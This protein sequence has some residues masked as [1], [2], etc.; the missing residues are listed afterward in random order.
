MQLILQTQKMGNAAV[1]RCKGRLV[2]GDEIRALQMEVE[3]LTPSTK[4]IALQLAE[5]NFIDSGAL[6]ALVRL[7]GVLRNTG[8][9]L[10]LCEVSPF[11]LQVLQATNLDRVFHLYVSER[12]AIGASSVRGP[13]PEDASRPF[14]ARVVCID[15][16]SDLLAYLRV[17]LQRSGYDVFT[18]R[19]PSDAVIF[20]KTTQSSIV[21]CGPGMSSNEPALRNFRQSA[22]NV[23]L[24]MLPLDFSTAEASH[25][26][27]DLVKR[28][29]T[30]LN[31]PG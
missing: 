28:V 10:R 24:L 4:Q 3:N 16:S 9:D 2:T 18:T 26:G 25:A 5:V 8:G 1:I 17:L 21:I 15:T 23:P 11:V 22:P 13:H 29:Q 30:L 12:E 27:M 19:Q 31:A 14:R 6:G 20:V 7:F